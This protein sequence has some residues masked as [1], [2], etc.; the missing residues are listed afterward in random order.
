MIDCLLI[1]H[2]EMNFPEYETMIRKTGVN[3][4]AYRDLNLVFIHIDGKPYTF[5]DVFNRL[6]KNASNYK[7][8]GPFGVGDVLHP[9][10]A[11]L[12]TYLTRR[13]Y[14]FDYINAFQWQQV[15]LADKLR[16]HEVV[17][18]AIITTFYVSVLPILEIVEFVR[19]H[20]DKA[21]I[22]LGG[23]FVATQ[24]KNEDPTTIDFLFNSIG[25]DIYVNSSQGET[26]LTQIIAALKTNTSLLTVPNLYYKKGSKYIKTGVQ[27][28][29]NKLDDNM[30][31]WSLF[32]GQVGHFATLRSVI[33]CPFS[34]SFCGYPEHAGKY[35]TISVELLEQELDAI[36]AM[37]TVKS[38]AFVDDTFNVPPRRF[39]K[40]LK[41]MIKNQ[42]DFKWHA[43]YRCQFATDETV[44]M[45]KDSG[46]E[47][48]YLG[49]ESGSQEILDNMNK[50][51]KV[52]KYKE[53]ISL[54]NKYNILSHAN[55]MVGFPGETDKTVQESV[56]LIE[57]YQPS[58]FRFQLW[59]CEPIT[60]IWQQ[61]EKY[62][63]KGSHFE[64]Q[65]NTM[66]VT[67][68]ANIVDELFCT[69]KNSVWLQQYNL[70]LFGFFRVLHRG[71]TLAQLTQFM[72]VFNEAIKDKL[73]SHHHDKEIS[74]AKL[75]MLEAA[76]YGKME[77]S[78]EQTPSNQ[79]VLTAEFDFD[80]SG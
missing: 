31:D 71:M 76:Y 66:D 11:Y 29:N 4:G 5:A 8:F 75:K 10:I 62:G 44:A 9:A 56:D 51:V 6:F 24:L 35:Q 33:S 59:Y 18:V 19:K 65:H 3:S 70:E 47:G 12:G 37:G 64:W 26:T 79:E 74:Y 43:Y 61:R 69:V 13:G 46:C 48:V 14:R 78:V 1:G 77:P 23:P 36:A 7:D 30:V 45:M 41:M 50:A 38:I 28:E 54:L 20:N 63:I 22:I 49:I 73:L 72:Q 16:Q 2:N 42:Y 39:E 55:F 58:F 15:E 53:G 68:A 57:E 80:F 17:T 21:K 40:I 34:C 25:A 27:I 60:P 52:A 32:S 67:T